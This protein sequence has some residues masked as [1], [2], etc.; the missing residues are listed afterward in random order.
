MKVLLIEDDASTAAYVAA[1]LREEGH[2]VD[3]VSSGA[4]GLELALGRTY[5]VAVIDRMLPGLDGLSLLRAA[6]ASG[7][8]VPAIFLT[9]VGG[10]DDRVEGLEAGADDYLLKPFAFSE[11]MARLNA[12]ARRGAP[13]R[14]E[15]TVLRVGELE[16]NLIAR[17]VT[18]AGRPVDLQPRE[19]RLLEYMMRNRGRVLTRTMLLERVWEF[20]FDPRTN[21]VETHVSRLRAKVD[22]P[23][24][25][26][27]IRTVRGSGYVIDAPS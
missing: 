10:V 6:R 4:L 16:M 13:E 19:F 22:R 18:R 9:A 25:G 20:H 23:F 5:D 15:E 11:L 7:S 26:E 3:H 8:R 17:T 21:V 2:E 12:L 24:D 1:G 27:M 14:R